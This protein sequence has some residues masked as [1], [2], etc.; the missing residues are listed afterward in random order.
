MT[1][2]PAATELDAVVD[3][4]RVHP[5]R[6]NKSAIGLVTEVLGPSDWLTGPGDDAAAVDALGAKVIACGEALLPR[7]VRADPYGAGIAAVLCNVN[8]VAASGG[9]PLG[10][11]DTI[12]AP[13][14]VARQALAGMRHAA[15]LYDVPIVGG[16]LTPHDG[17]PSLSAFAVGTASNV[18]SV[19]HV[20]PG[21]SLVFACALG[22]TM[23]PDFP[24]YA[25]F[26]QRGRRCAGDVRVLAEIA[27]SG[28]CVAA[29]DVSMAGTVGSLGMLLEWSGLG[30]GLDLDVL[31]R[32]DDVPMADWLTCFPSFAFLLCV[33]PGREDECIEP[34][35]ARGLDAAVVGRIEDGGPMGTVSL[36]LGGKA[37]VALDVTVTGLGR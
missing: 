32:P 34:F 22:G 10:I 18:L 1:T 3:A 2:A 15:E 5:G 25:A 13:E 19:T 27:R 6:L 28:A 29:K 21:Q 11:V 20:R 8:D 30:A 16:H 14:D 9:V 37:R 7:F 36:T 35:T 24:F 17:E 4:V 23:R 12:V 33:P 31:P 26:E